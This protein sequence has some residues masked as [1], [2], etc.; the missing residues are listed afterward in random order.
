M[1]RQ[2]L[3]SAAEN[4]DHVLARSSRADFS[5]FMQ[6]SLVR[7][8]IIP[9]M[10]AGR[11]LGSPLMVEGGGGGAR[12]ALEGR[13]RVGGDREEAGTY[14]KCGNGYHVDHPCW[15]RVHITIT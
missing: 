14:D 9:S 2:W 7:P 11:Q 3:L 6:D 1:E 8:V 12:R 5:S 10:P 4:D 15:P 13:D